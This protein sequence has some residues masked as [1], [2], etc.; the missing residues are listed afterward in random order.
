MCLL[1]TQWSVFLTKK[2][3]RKFLTLKSILLTPRKCKIF[4]IF[5]LYFV[6]TF[7]LYLKHSVLQNLMDYTC[8]QYEYTLCIIN[9]LLIILLFTIQNN[10]CMMETPFLWKFLHYIAQINNFDFKKYK[11]FSW[12]STLPSFIPYIWIALPHTFKHFI[13][14]FLEHFI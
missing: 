2:E 5:P 14:T 7:A 4:T 9:T 11:F 12:I 8:W 6:F 3:L 10:F 13:F 1:K